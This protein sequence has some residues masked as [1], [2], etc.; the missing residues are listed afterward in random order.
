MTPPSSGPV[1]VI[2]TGDRHWSPGDLAVRILRRLKDRHG[3]ALVIVH[4]SATGIDTAFESA[5]RYL[6]V[7]TEPHPADWETLGPAAGPRR[8]QEMVDAGARFVLAC[9]RTLE[10]SRGTLDCVRRA[11]RAGIPVWLV[12]S[13]RPEPPRRV[14]STVR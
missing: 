8:N 12:S 7:R 11:N 1:R 4:G 13:E 3:D 14:P 9:H 10:R 6:G 5:A 2:V